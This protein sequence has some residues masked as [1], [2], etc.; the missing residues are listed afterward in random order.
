MITKLPKSEDG[1]SVTML[2]NNNEY[3][4]TWNT[5]AMKFTLWKVSKDKGYPQ[6]EKISTVSDSPVKLYEKVEKLEGK[7]AIIEK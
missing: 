3:L 5:K 6:Y 7:W 4:I 1:H 2:V